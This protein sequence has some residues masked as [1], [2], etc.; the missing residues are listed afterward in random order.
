MK[1]IH[2]LPISRFVGFKFWNDR[3]CYLFLQR[4]SHVGSNISAVE[5]TPITY[6]RL[7]EECTKS[8]SLSEGKRFHAHMIINGFNPNIY[9]TNRLCDLYVKCGRLKDARQ[10]FDEMPGRDV[11]S[12]ARMIAGYARNGFFE[13]SLQLFVEMPERTV[14]AWNAIISGYAQYGHG[15][16][17][18][19]IFSELQH[20]GLKPN[21][22]TVSSVLSVCSSLVS[23]QDGKQDMLDAGG[24]KMHAKF[25]KKCLNE[26]W[27]HGLR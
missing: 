24:W 12:W 21:R 23:L 7:L 18:L 20:A 3:Y 9:T 8:K 14:V 25:S 17:A 26:T 1:F 4:Y 15:R 5:C 27:F 16:E 6:A 19:E 2:L 13:D 22:I 11:F 10:V